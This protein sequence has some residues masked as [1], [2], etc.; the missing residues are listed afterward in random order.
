MPLFSLEA[1]TRILSAIISDERAAM[2]GASSEASGEGTWDR[3]SIVGNGN[4]DIDSVELIGVATAV[5]SFFCLYET[6]DEDR[7]LIKRTIGSWAKICSDGRAGEPASIAFRVT[8]SHEPDGRVEHER[9]L[10]HA[11]ARAYAP[12]VRLSRRVVSYVPSNSPAGVVHVELL[13]RELNIEVAQ[14]PSPNAETRT[15]HLQAEDHIVADAA[16][17]HQLASIGTPF[18]PGTTGTI[19]DRAGS[20][21]LKQELIQ[22]GLE[23]LNDPFISEDGTLTGLHAS[24]LSSST[25]MQL[26]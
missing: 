4:F 15:M 16:A 1:T 8:N 20:D 11:Y 10:L 7:L 26:H 25:T 18:L 24:A 17:W 14:G 2:R 13:A 5:S 19:T 12:K 6:G 9:S 3:N 21:S 23:A 22:N